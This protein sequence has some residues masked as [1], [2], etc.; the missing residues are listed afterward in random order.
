MGKRQHQKDKLYLTTT[1]WSTIYG[2]RRPNATRQAEG[3]EFKRLPF[4]HC[5]LSLQPFEHPLCTPEGI[6][7]DIMNIVPFIK[8]YGIDPASG[9]PID[10]KKLIRLNFA[11]NADGKYHCPVLYKVFNENTHIV[12]IKTTGNVFSYDAVDQLNLRAKN[13]KDLL[14]DEPFTRQD[15]I[16]LQDPSDLEKFNL[17]RFHH[18]KHNLKVID[19]EEERMKSDPKY[20]LRKMNAET[21]TILDTLDKEYKPPAEKTEKVVKKADKFNAA[22]Y[23]TGAVA[24][25]FTSTVMEVATAHEPAVLADDVVR[26]SMVK[27]KGYV[28]LQTTHGNLN[29]EL[30][31]DAVP[32]TCE[33]F[34]GLC[35]KGYYDNTKFH[36]SIRHFMIQGGDPTGTGKGGESLWG[37]PFKDEFK[38]NLVHQGRGML[39]MANEGPN[40]NKSQF[41]VTYRSCRHLDSKHTVFG[42]LVGGLEA[43][44]VIEAVETDNKDRPIEDIVIIKAVVFVDPFEEVNEE[45]KKKREEEEAK[46]KQDGSEQMEKNLKAKRVLKEFHKGVGKYI[47]P[48]ETAKAVSEPAEAEA[49]AKKVKAVTGKFGDFSCW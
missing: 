4:D 32:K 7:Y 16:T 9:K 24:A 29:F 3:S 15:I 37:K 12:A 49:P 34:V 31:C 21:R 42:K 28:Q 10:A 38:P 46:K 18:L 35:K 48:A 39:S 27:K 13:F 45:L 41:F 30:Y 47:D 8:K 25:S 40:M 22:H 43:L 2:G 1:E 36:R 33:N 5:A 20:T 23:S 44:N 11:K 14:T 17:S 26:Y 19:P 6:I